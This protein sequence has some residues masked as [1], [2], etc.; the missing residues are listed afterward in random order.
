MVRFLQALHT[1]A[2]VERTFGSVGG[3]WEFNLRDL[4]RWCYLIVERSMS[5][6]RGW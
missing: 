2:N 6:E 3:P 4:M 1:A 5:S